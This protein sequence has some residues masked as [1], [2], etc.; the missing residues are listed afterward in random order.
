M[1]TTPPRQTEREAYLV[2]RE[3][4]SWCEVHKL[5]PGSKMTVGR[6]AGSRI[7]LADEKCSR[8]HAEVEFSAA[9]WL[10]RD[11]DSRNGTRINGARIH[12]TALLATGDVIRIGNLELLFTFDIARSLDGAPANGA[13]G[14]TTGAK[15]PSASEELE[16]PGPAILERKARTRYLTETNLFAG[17][18]ESGAREAIGALFR[19][20]V[21]M[22]AARDVVEA[23]EMALDGLIEAI[24]VELG[25]V[26]LFPADVP[27]RGDPSSLRIMAYRAPEN[28]P[29]HK[30]SSRLSRAALQEREAILGIDVAE[31]AT[32]FQTLSDMQAH[33][34]IC[35][36]LRHNDRITGLVHL[37]SLRA[38]AILGANALEFALAVADQLALTLANLAQ[39]DSLTDEL[40]KACHQNRSLR[41]L[42]EVESDLIGGSV[43]MRRLRDSIA[44]VARSDV[45]ALVRGESGV[46]KEL[47]ARAIHFNSNR[48]EAPFI[49]LNCAALTETLLESEL[50]GHE[51][52][53]FTG[54][55][56]R[57]FG[58]F[59]Q[60][61]TGTLFLDEVGEMPMSIQAKFLRV[62]EGHAF[63]RVGGHETVRVDARVVAATNRDL[64]KAVEAGE[65]RKD[66]YYR[67]QI[68]E[69][70]VPSLRE[71][72]GDIPDLAEHFVERS[73]RRIGRSVPAISKDAMELLV[74][75]E[76]PG[77]IREL[78]NVI[79]RALVF[80]EGNEIRPADIRLT[81]HSDPSAWIDAVENQNFQPRSLESL[82]REHI[83]RTL[84]WTAG[85]KREAA[86]ILE[87][88]RSTL[89]RKIE[90]YEIK[91]P[92]SAGD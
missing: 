12:G 47:V 10:I 7:V 4:G 69:I 91:L 57:K 5:A 58:K 46:G 75:N 71:H 14:L 38:S 89:D 23:S 20:V 13:G 49:C 6:D 77:N 35:A 29:Y 27:D 73:C 39:R 55:T 81:H 68:L 17:D 86:R 45:T 67:L 90:R 84:A 41:Q 61:H 92:D 80:L 21:K 63:E 65:F 26:L 34:V 24:D 87:I 2:A 66:L 78:R 18:H 42:L 33:S 28:T 59:E 44:R 85:N 48:R 19:L 60:A 51:Q 22:V 15:S 9:G 40:A 16:S 50:F 72:G 3:G 32:G 88:N 54:A 79:E 70:Q 36:P 53:S 43:P 11:L 64:E 74:R 76:W 30:V 25:A 82:E 52:G 1:A 31:E 37:Y 56:N 83:A 8:R 62:L